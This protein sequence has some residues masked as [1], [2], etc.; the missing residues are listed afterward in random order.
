LYE[1][2]PALVD[3][4]VLS[5]DEADR[6]R[7]HYGPVEKRGSVNLALLA[8][9]VLGALLVGGGIILL[10]AE[11]WDQLSR[12]QRTA[13]AVVP[14]LFSLVLAGWT[15]RSRSGSLAWREGSSTLLALMLGSATAILVETYRVPI[16][17]RTS[18][19][20]WVV[21]VG[22]LSL[23]MRSNVVAVIF[24]IGATVWA[25]TGEQGGGHPLWFWPLAAAVVVPH[26]HRVM[27]ENRYGVRASNLLWAIAVCVSVAT[28]F[29]LQKA[30]PGLWI[31]VYAGLFALLLVAG[32]RWFPDGGALWQRPLQFVGAGGVLVL[33][34]M[35]T[36]PWPWDQIGWQHYRGG[37]GFIERGGFPD[38]LFAIG[39]PA[40]AVVLLVATVDRRHRF[41]PWLWCS[42]PVIAAVGYPLVASTNNEIIGTVLFNLYLFVL[43]LGTLV[44]G[45]RDQE[46]AI[47]N[48]GMVILAVLI[49]VRFFD[50]EIAEIV[51]GLAFI[52]VGAG[53]LVANLILVRKM[54]AR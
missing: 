21:L 12:L 6:L 50:S 41:L 11:H 45:L 10:L 1:E 14:L 22:L 39:V 3:Q 33:A 20:L 9:G 53:F 37:G 16:S 52:A 7:H 36:F 18:L 49:V 44:V 8:F 13:V 38:L 47:V 42:A 40:A 5:P 48:A 4:Q 32:L 46:I 26:L 24:L 25:T 51:K 29:S 34:L 35:L 54:S 43:G 30:M 27:R 17:E 2:L 23:V 31:V 15:L 28:G 19:L